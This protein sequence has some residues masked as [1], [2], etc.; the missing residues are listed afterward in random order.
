[1]VTDI[2][3]R[4]NV[5]RRSEKGVKYTERRTILDVKYE[6]CRLIGMKARPGNG[7]SV[8]LTHRNMRGLHQKIEEFEKKHF[9]RLDKSMTN[10]FRYN[11]NAPLDYDRWFHR[12]G[13]GG[14]AK[15]RVRQSRSPLNLPI[16][17]HVNIDCQ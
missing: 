7:A 10:M 4:P 11:A 8:T 2:E 12:C 5:E 15:V 14:T 13:C 6:V 17:S 1:M 9:P 3:I 16:N